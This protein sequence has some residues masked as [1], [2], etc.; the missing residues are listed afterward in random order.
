MSGE[1]C[2][3]RTHAAGTSP[4]WGGTLLQ[5]IFLERTVVT[6][7]HPGRLVALL[8]AIKARTCGTIVAPCLMFAVAYGDGAF[9]MGGSAYSSANLLFAESHTSCMDGRRFPVGLAHN[10]RTDP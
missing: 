10:L 5:G 9:G 4:V 2:T 6:R 8:E 7:V 3:G 1:V